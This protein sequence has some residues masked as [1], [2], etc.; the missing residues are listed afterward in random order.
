M[1]TQAL[2]TTTIKARLFRDFSDTSRLTILEALRAGPL[3]VTALV[4]V[5]DLSQSNVSN[6]LECLRDCCLVI[7]TPQGRLQRVHSSQRKG[8]PY[9]F[10]FLP[11]MYH[12]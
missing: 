10:L 6:H 2:Q 8:N 12:G 9:D 11:H 5:T 3:T 7:S 4:N 1:L